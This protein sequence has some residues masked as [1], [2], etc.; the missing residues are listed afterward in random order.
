MSRIFQALL[1][2]LM[3][4]FATQANAIFTSPDTLDPTIPGVGKNRYAYSFND[5]I[6]KSD[7]SGNATLQETIENIWDS[8]L[9]SHES[10]QQRQMERLAETEIDLWY[11]QSE[12]DLGNRSQFS[13]E[14]WRDHYTAKQEDLLDKLDES[15]GR[16][17]LGEVGTVLEILSAKGAVKPGT[18]RS[19]ISGST[20]ILGQSSAQARRLSMQLAAE[21]AAGVPVP[22]AITGYT[23]HGINSAISRDG[24]GVSAKAILDTWHSPSK[25]EFVPT[26]LGPSFRFTGSDSVVV[27]N[28]QGQVVTTWARGS[29]GIRGW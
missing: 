27:L 29:L 14:H 26:K 17:L 12:Y 21:R 19:L 3:A 11:N 13:Y 22:S 9:G 25:I 24:V 18:A 5:P 1:I 16:A 28:A 8:I 10:R 4:T 7:P 2:V 20:R 15:R 23:K 6:N